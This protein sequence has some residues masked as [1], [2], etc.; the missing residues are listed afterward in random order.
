MVK[1]QKLGNDFLKITK[2]FGEIIDLTVESETGS[3]VYPLHACLENAT[4]AAYNLVDRAYLIKGNLE[5]PRGLKFEQLTGMYF[6]RE[7]DG[8]TYILNTAIPEP[9]APGLC[10][11]YANKS[12]GLINILQKTTSSMD[13]RDAWGNLVEKYT[14]REKDVPVYWYTTLRSDK[15]QNNGKLDQTIY[16]AYVPARYNLC[17]GDKITRKDF[18]DGGYND[19]VFTVESVEVAMVVPVP[20][21]GEL[22]GIVSIQLIKNINKVLVED[23]ETTI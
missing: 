14:V 11:I 18:I 21:T 15:V 5:M 12:N 2:D 6:K 7:T 23:G 8:G 13:D 3:K 19:E 10:F 22:L 17:K 9:I 1:F 20:E 16:S 4:Q